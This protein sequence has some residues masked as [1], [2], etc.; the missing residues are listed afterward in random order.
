M[1]EAIALPP[2]PPSGY[3]TVYWDF[4]DDIKGSKLPSKGDALRYSFIFIKMAIREA[5]TAVIEKIYEFW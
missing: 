2:A 3:A 1:R 5:S 4:L